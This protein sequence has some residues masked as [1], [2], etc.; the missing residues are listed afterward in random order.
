MIP[1]L[2]FTRLGGNKNI[3]TLVNL[4]EHYISEI[5]E[6][7]LL[8]FHGL[9]NNDERILKNYLSLIKI[10]SLTEPIKHLAIQ[11]KKSY[12]LKTIDSII[13][14]SAVYYEIPFI[15]AGKA[16]YKINELEIIPASL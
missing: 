16:F 9:G 1:I 3:A 7:E 15:T 4:K 11:L 10:V 13:A 8:G 14:A 6:I 12:R 5:T 2:L